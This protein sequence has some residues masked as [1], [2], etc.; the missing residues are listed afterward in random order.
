MD[1]TPAFT[2]A[3]PYL[4]HGAK[5]RVGTKVVNSTHTG[6]QPWRHGRDGVISEGP[7][8]A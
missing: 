2:K 8:S 5:E 3:H 7:W 4:H 1:G 6:A